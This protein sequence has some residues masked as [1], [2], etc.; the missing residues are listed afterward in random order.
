M[1]GETVSQLMDWHLIKTAPKDGTPI[2]SF[3][4]KALDEIGI[5]KWVQHAPENIGTWRND[6][7]EP[8]HWQPLP[9]PPNGQT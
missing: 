7:H 4:P 1:E 3:A 6:G 8:T 2:L 5:A 9:E